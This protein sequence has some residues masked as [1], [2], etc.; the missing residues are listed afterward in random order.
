M[1]AETSDHKQR[2]RPFK[3]GQSG[4]P[5]G[6]PRGAGLPGQVRAAIAARADDILA[7]LLEKAT[8]GDV[9]A[10]RVL[11]DR[12]TPPLKAESLPTPVPGLADAATLTKA[13]ESILQA[14]AIGEVSPDTGT[15]L[16]NALAT[17]AKLKELDDIEARLRA[18]EAKHAQGTK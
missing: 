13:A 1:S 16:V 6:R 2:G 3:P 11:L 18:L 12:I 4:N 10:A 8:A 17:L 7:A 9:Q 5:A 14:V 15:G